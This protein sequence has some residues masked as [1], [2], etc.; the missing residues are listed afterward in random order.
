M[1]DM[2]EDARCAAPAPWGVAASQPFLPPPPP[3]P[4]LG[5]LRHAASAGVND[6][7]RP[8]FVFKV[9]LKECS[10]ACFK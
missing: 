8:C 7:A 9:K 3:L 6:A 10:F 1:H 5:G 4:P 2:E